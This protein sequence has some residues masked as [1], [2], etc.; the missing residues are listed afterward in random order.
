M[1]TKK[2]LVGSIMFLSFI[3]FGL[4]GNSILPAQA[5]TA[6]KVV[7]TKSAVT[8]A[9]SGTKELTKIKNATVRKAYKTKVEKYALRNKIKTITSAVVKGMHE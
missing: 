6:K 3:S 5:A 4:L 1:K 9:A 2:Y 8:W 7:V